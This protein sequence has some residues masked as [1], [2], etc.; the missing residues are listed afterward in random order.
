[1]KK[2]P[3]T[4]KKA[5]GFFERNFTKPLS[6]VAARF[7]VPMIFA[8]AI[9]VTLS[10]AIISGIRWYGESF[11]MALLLSLSAGFFLSVG[12]DTWRE[13]RPHPLSLLWHLISVAYT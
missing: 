6:Q 4:T 8:G 2:S 7:P 5:P 11:W 10:I 12:I 3:K 13:Y 1:M 9:T